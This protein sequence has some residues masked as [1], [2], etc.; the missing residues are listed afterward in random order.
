MADEKRL[1]PKEL[2]AVDSFRRDLSMFLG[3]SLKQLDEMSSIGDSAVGYSA[4]QSI[5]LANAASLSVESARRALRVTR[6]LY[7]RCHDFSIDPVD[8]A[9]ELVRVATDLDLTEDIETKKSSLQRL[10]ALKDHYEAGSYA[11]S[12]GDIGRRT[13]RGNRCGLGYS[14]DISPTNKPDNQKD[15]GFNNGRILARQRGSTPRS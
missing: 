1:I 7:E 15:S 9:T 8:A 12:R 4:T 6:Y 11:E 13:L 2:V 10:M 14:T 5:E 3:L